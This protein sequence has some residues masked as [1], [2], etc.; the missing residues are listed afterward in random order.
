ML[1]SS[2]I[3]IVATALF[4]AGAALFLFWVWRRG[5]LSDFDA[6]ARVIFDMRDLRL[7]RPWEDAPARAE[8]QR[9]FGAPE[10]ASAGE[11]GGGS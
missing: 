1:P 5:M 6:Q 3:V 2:I 4:T 7:V 8:R 11:W 10:A 9:H